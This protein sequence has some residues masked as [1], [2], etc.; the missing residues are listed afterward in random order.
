MPPKKPAPATGNKKTQEKKKEKIIEDKTFGLKNKKGAKQ[1]KY[2]KNV[3]QQ[4]KYGQQSSRQIAEADKTTKK[5]DKKKELDELNELFK[6]VVA[7]QK[8]SKGNTHMSPFGFPGSVLTCVSM[9][10][11]PLWE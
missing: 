3:T 4:V 6:P 10:S 8:V 5:A 2:I 11:G 9:R 7:A 1:Q